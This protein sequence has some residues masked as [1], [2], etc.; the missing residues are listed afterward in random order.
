MS[1][2]NVDYRW[3]VRKGKIEEAKKALQRLTTKENPNFNVNQTVALMAHTNAIEKEIT[4]GPGTGYRDC[5]KGTDLRRTEIVC[6]V[7]M[8]QIFCGQPFGGIGAYFFEAAGFPPEQSFSLQLGM[9]G[10]AFVGAIISWFL[11]RIVGRRTLYLYGLATMFVILMAIGILG[12][13]PN[14]AGL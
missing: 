8:I 6:C 3:L 1:L 14:A 5:F 2:T 9:T 7:W 11:M 10:I 4:S 13:P 12:I